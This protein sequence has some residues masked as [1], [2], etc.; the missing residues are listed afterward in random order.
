MTA[1]QPTPPVPDAVVVLPTYNEAENLRDV[2]ARIRRAAPGVAILVVDDASPDGTGGIADALAAE[3]RKVS[4]LHR[5]GDPGLG[6]AIAAGMREALG[7]GAPHTITMDCDLSHD[8]AEIPRLLAAG[9]DVAIGSRYVAGGRLPDWSLHRKALSA[10]ANLFV[11]VLFHLPARDCTSGYRAYRSDTL[12]KVPFERLQSAGYSFEVE[13]LF[14]VARLGGEGL[15]E[16]PITFLDRARG[17]SKM[18][19]REALVGAVSL[20]KLRLSLL[21]AR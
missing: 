17:K 8:P 16:V 2:V 21:F 3:D 12:A 10:A 14:W 19:G 9:G 1:S 13:V 11:R 6:R 18:G 4:V 5:M 20:L 7:R 15:R